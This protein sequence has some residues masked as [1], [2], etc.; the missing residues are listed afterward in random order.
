MAFL[1]LFGALVGVFL[2]TNVLPGNPAKFRA[3]A[4][5]PP[6][7]VR[8]LEIQMG[9]D[10]PMIV[11]FKNYLVRLSKGDLGISWNTRRP[12]TKDLADRLPATLELALTSFLIAVSV[13]L[14]LGILAAAKKNSY[15]DH[16]CRLLTTLS[17]SLPVFWVGTMLI[18]LLFY[19]LGWAAAPTGRLTIGLMP[20][21]KITGLYVLDSILTGN[22][23]TLISSLKRL[24][25]PALALSFPVIGAIAK[26]ARTSMLEVLEADYIRTARALGLNRRKTILQDALQNALIPVITILAMVFGFLI[27]GN[28]IVEMIFAWPGIG[29]YAWNA[30][31][32]KDFN[33]V[34]GF[35]LFVS[36]SYVFL[37][38]TADILYG[39]VDPRIRL[40]K[41]T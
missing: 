25:L 41:Y 32:T 22:M 21:T 8:E 40:G 12:V 28:V 29:H 5:A 23:E 15:I 39:L 2:L 16:F 4:F 18:Y 20:P 24:I 14:P 37:N 36:A 26:M 1:T 31:V 30:M 35:L 13:A 7:A 27:A 34:R 11:Q 9:L 19:Q 17:V 6:E 38:L 33:G 3:G 10:K